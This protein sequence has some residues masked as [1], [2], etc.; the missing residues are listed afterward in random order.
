MSIRETIL[1]E[2]TNLTSKERNQAYGEP[3]VNLGNIADLWTTYINGKFAGTAVD[4]NRFKIEASDV[5]F[6][7]V[8]QKIA[9]TFQGSLKDNYVDAAAYVAIAGE[10]A[11][12]EFTETVKDGPLTPLGSKIL[13]SWETRSE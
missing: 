2:A 9:R 1:S 11:F 7:N 3:I 4:P 8:L 5:A 10:C 6:M 13:H 12:E